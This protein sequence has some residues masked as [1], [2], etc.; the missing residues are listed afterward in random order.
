MPKKA[1]AAAATCRHRAAAPRKSGEHDRVP[2]LRVERKG[3]FFLLIIFIKEV[4]EAVGFLPVGLRT[5]E[6]NYH[7]E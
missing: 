4:R 1:H 7:P 6:S 2:V 5:R 3:A